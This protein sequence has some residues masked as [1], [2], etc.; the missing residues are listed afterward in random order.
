[1]V[2]ISVNV[3]GWGTKDFSEE[4]LRIYL[5]RHKPTLLE[6][7]KDL[8]DGKISIKKIY[9]IISEYKSK[10]DANISYAGTTDF[11]DC[12]GLSFLD[13]LRYL[14]IQASQAK[15]LKCQ[16]FRGM[17]GGNP[18]TRIDVISRLK[19]FQNK[20]RDCKLLIE[21]HGG[22]E[23]S[24]ENIKKL[25]DY[26]NYDFVI[27]FQNVLESKLTFKEIKNIIPKTRIQYYHDRNL[28]YLD[29]GYIEHK[30]SILEKQKWSTYTST[31]NILWE[32]K[33]IGKGRIL[34]FLK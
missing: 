32:P 25:V 29:D 26:T 2:S 21:I 33:K 3:S 13:Y 4:D 28:T 27:D 18:K 16:Y 6:I 20:L 34:E 14:E 24:L 8:V 11:V 15:F 7:S 31:R 1:M 12:S 22:W 19:K 5:N 17:I 30:E 10:F 23:S 9:K